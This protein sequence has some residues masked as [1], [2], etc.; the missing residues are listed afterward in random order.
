MA[1][2]AWDK[3]QRQGIKAL[4]Q[5]RRVTGTGDAGDGSGLGADLRLLCLVR[6]GGVR[7]FVVAWRLLQADA[8]EKGKEARG[9]VALPCLVFHTAQGYRRACGQ[10]LGKRGMGRW[11]RD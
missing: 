1:A 3:T 6:V 11:R 9:R 4:Y 8:A 5:R 10:R 2:D 7:P